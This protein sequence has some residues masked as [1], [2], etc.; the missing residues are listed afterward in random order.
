M[1]VSAFLWLLFCGP[2]YGQNFE[3]KESSNFQNYNIPPGIV[4]PMKF[5][6]TLDLSYKL[7]GTINLKTYKDSELRVGKVLS[8]EQL[9]SLKEIDIENYQYYTTANLYFEKL[10]LKV[11]NLYTKNELWY[12]YIFDQNLKNNLLTIK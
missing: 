11:T 1:T 12:I 8:P 9:E 3:R 6:T 5:D 7:N 10:S 2:S 4:F